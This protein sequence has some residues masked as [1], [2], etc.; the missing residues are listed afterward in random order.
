MFLCFVFVVVWFVCVIGVVIYVFVFVDDVW[1][2][3][4]VLF[5]LCVVCVLVVCDV[6]FFVW[7]C[8]MNVD[9]VFVWVCVGENL[10]KYD[11]LYL[12]FGEVYYVELSVFAGSRGVVDADASFACRRFARKYVEVVCVV[13]EVCVYEDEC[14]FI[15]VVCVDDVIVCEC[16]VSYVEIKRLLCLCGDWCLWVL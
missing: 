1:L 14:V 8:V 4:K 16:G 5:V 11:K 10:C 13:F 7:M 2:S 6:V 9:D 12:V 15:D 3:V